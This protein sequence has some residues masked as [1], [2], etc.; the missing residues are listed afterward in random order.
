[1]RISDSLVILFDGGLKT[2]QTAQESPD[3]AQKFEDANFF[4]ETITQALIDRLLTISPSGRE[5]HDI[6]GNPSILFS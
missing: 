6:E 4:A 5:I 2:A 1:L 3:L